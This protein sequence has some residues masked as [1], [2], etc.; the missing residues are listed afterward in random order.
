MSRREGTTSYSTV[1]MMRLN[2]IG[3]KCYRSVAKLPYS[4]SNF[5]N[6]GGVGKDEAVSSDNNNA[7]DIKKKEANEILRYSLAKAYY[8]TGVGSIVACGVVSQCVDVEI[9][10]TALLSS[11]VFFG[12]FESVTKLSK[13]LYIGP[14]LCGGAFGLLSTV[15]ANIVGPILYSKGLPNMFAEPEILEFMYWNVPVLTGLV[16]LTTVPVVLKHNMWLRE[17]DQY[18]TSEVTASTTTTTSGSE[19]SSSTWSKTSSEKKE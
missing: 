18:S 3:K 17:I 11:I 10:P 16:G 1:R 7:Q 6:F 13:Y 14:A 9:V 15:L 4:F 2:L 19:E 12:A 5:S 8:Y